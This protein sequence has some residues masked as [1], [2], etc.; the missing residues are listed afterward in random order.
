[1]SKHALN[2]AS[3][4]S[5]LNIM[6]KLSGILLALVFLP[7]LSQGQTTCGDPI[8]LFSIAVTPACGGDNG[9]ITFN[10]A[11]GTYT[12]FWPQNISFGPVAS[13]LPAGTYQIRVERNGMPECFVDT[14]LTVN[15]F[16]AMVPPQVTS[17][18][19]SNCFASNGAVQLSPDTYNYAWSN[20]EVGAFNDGL[21]SGVYTVTATNANGCTASITAEVPNVNPLEFTATVVK[22]SKCGRKTGEVSFTATGGSGQYSYSLGGEQV[23]GLG[24][25]PQF[26]IVVDNTNGC[27]DTAF[28]DIPVV[29]AE[30]QIL[31]TANTPRCAGETGNIAVD[32]L[33][34]DFFQTPFTFSITTANGIPMP[35]PDSIPAGS[36]IVYVA[37]ADS[38]VL[39]GQPFVMT[40]PIPLQISAAVTPGTCAQGGQINLTASGGTGTLLADWSDLNGISNGFERKNLLA[41]RYEAIVFD[42]LFCKDT[43]DVT[44]NNT[45]SRTDTF[46]LLV[47]KNQTGSFC[48][49]PAVGFSAAD[50]TYQLVTP[51]T[52]SAF[53][54]W[55]LVGNCVNY[56]ALGNT[57][58]DVDFICVKIT[59]PALN[60]TDT[61][62]IQ[63][64]II[65][66]EPSKELVNFTTQINTT[67]AACGTIPA[68]LTNF[69][70]RPLNVTALSG[71]TAFGQ[72]GINT[73]NA[74]MTY[75][76]YD[77]P[78]F[79]ADSIAIA[80]CDTALNCHIICYVPSILPFFDCSK[81]IISADSVFLPTTNCEVGAST[82]IAIPYANILNYNIIDNG[83]PYNS[84]ALGCAEASVVSYAVAQLPGVGT[85]ANGPYHLNE[86]FI[87]GTPYTTTFEN[88]NELLS[89]MNSIDPIPGWFLENGINI[90][91]GIPANNYGPLRV[92]NAN[93]ETSQA[94]AAVKTAPLGSDLR[95]STGEHHLIL[96]RIQTG[97]S[98]TLR[99]Q[100]QCFDCPPVHPFMPDQF[101]N[102]A[103]EAPSCAVDTVFRTN[104]AYGDL[105]KWNLFDNN[106]A[107]AAVN[108]G[109]NVGFV[110]DTGYHLMRLQH[111]ITTCEYFIS[112]YFDCRNAPRDTLYA[113]LKVGENASVCPDQSLVAAP[114]ITIFHICEQK[115]LD[116]NA[117]LTYDE[118]NWC[119]LLEGEKVGF[120]T[121]C[122]QLCNADGICATTLVF[123][124]VTPA[125]TDEKVLIYNGISPNG[126][127]KNDVWRV[128]GIDNYPAN[129]VWVFT[130]EGYEVF[131]QKN[132]NNAWGGTWNEKTLPAGTYYYVVD[133]GDG[134]RVLKG[135]L[136]VSY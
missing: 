28:F 114:I 60:Q 21:N 34:G 127:G 27:A 106:I 124:E 79:F 109:G 36:Y 32:V 13:N 17:I 72:F 87:N 118:Q 58:Q 3:L 37:D 113:T 2:F 89:W 100:V 91:G 85:T 44:V 134:S 53:G 69:T 62:C 75:S 97:C 46:A 112:F 93:N 8:Q 23:F 84:G 29:T 9:S 43:L 33:P 121:L 86:W 45:C 102:I 76:A 96:K 116:P 125:D 63:I 126:D 54:S 31:V 67:T 110:L 40:E 11:P 7:F 95:F 81:G 123:V 70:V 129:E 39:P 103:W 68:T 133:L 132:Y 99:V 50:A 64:S 101:G 5:N 52:S 56:A 115:N 74:C 12:W 6:K 105:D 78:Q 98:D 90:I 108:T 4:K 122:L 73:A 119:A 111:K 1:M 120:D 55:A 80:L 130:R 26:G 25:G 88:L 57:G 51:G 20:T 30:G 16:A 22:P 135:H 19:P 104:I 131:H 136:A 71:N 61:V 128:V 117:A 77:V 65:A 42:S 82:C 14:L 15:A 48:M 59:Q 66:A 107:L 35:R 47:V 18:T 92:T 24:P 41:G 49:E 10:I 94:Q 83:Q 38:C